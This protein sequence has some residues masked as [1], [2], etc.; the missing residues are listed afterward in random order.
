MMTAGLCAKDGTK[1]VEQFAFEATRCRFSY[2]LSIRFRRMFYELLLS[3]VACFLKTD[4]PQPVRHDGGIALVSAFS[5]RFNFFSLI[6]IMLSC[7]ANFPSCPHTIRSFRLL[8]S[9]ILAVIPVGA[10]RNAGI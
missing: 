10:Q 4:D 3:I 1:K 6:H 2:R 8:Y 5:G 7:L 9:F